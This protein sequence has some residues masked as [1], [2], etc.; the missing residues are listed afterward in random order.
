MPP[1][2]VAARVCLTAGILVGALLPVGD[3]LVL[4]FLDAKDPDQ[5]DSLLQYYQIEICSYALWLIIFLSIIKSVS[6]TIVPSI[7]SHEACENTSNGQEE[8]IT[9]AHKRRIV[10][11]WIFYGILLGTGNGYL[12]IRFLL[13]LDTHPLASTIWNLFSF[14]GYWRTDLSKTT[15]KAQEEDRDLQEPLLLVA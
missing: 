9:M 11:H 13:G 7:Q 6:A 10:E 3:F 4:S 1:S 5:Q 15:A 14:W 2:N 8:S 12:G